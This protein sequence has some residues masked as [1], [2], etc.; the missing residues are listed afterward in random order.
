MGLLPE[1][2]F[3]IEIGQEKVAMILASRSSRA[4]KCAAWPQATRRHKQLVKA[5]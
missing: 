4:P 5:E 1:K 2:I 3:R